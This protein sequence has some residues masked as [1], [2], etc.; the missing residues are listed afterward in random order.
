MIRQ[1]QQRQVV[2]VR[3]VTHLSDEAQWFIAEQGA[4]ESRAG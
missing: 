2:E 4:R 1:H 3:R